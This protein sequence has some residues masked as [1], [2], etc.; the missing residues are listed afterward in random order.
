MI[1]GP[2][3]HNFEDIA[4]EL[5]ENGGGIEVKGREELVEEV[6]KLLKDRDLRERLGELAYESIKKNRGVIERSMEVVR[7]YIES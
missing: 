6:K 1:F 2:Y 4:R 5:K 3:M 7:D